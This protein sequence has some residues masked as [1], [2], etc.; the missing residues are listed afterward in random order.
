MAVTAHLSI[1]RSPVPAPPAG[2]TTSASRREATRCRSGGPVGGRAAA[3]LPVSGAHRG[4]GTA[5]FL[6]ARRLGVLGAG[7][8]GVVR[9]RGRGAFPV[10][11]VH[12]GRAAGGAGAVGFG[13]HALGIPG[14][15]HRTRRACGTSLGWGAMPR[16]SSG[17]PPARTV[18]E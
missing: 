1:V 13:G 6:A 17:N 9:E 2:G 14:G 11:R 16:S 12:D 3:W 7:H 15:S 4:G 8:A 5:E 10:A 18:R